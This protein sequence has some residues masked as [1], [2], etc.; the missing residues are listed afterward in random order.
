MRD[1]PRQ[2]GLCLSKS[3]TTLK[4]AGSSRIRFP[5]NENQCRKYIPE[6][7]RIIRVFE[8]KRSLLC[9]KHVD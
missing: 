9:Y 6:L 4:F 2:K 5:S 3:A 7:A 1:A 8:D